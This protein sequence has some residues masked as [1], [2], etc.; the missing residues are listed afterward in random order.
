MYK[1]IVNVFF[2]TKAFFAY[3]HIKSETMVGRIDTL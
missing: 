2:M 3:I 1:K